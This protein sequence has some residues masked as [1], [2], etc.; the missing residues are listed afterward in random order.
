MGICVCVCVFFV[1]FD[2]LAQARNF[3]IEGGLPVSCLPLLTAGFEL[4]KSETPGMHRNVLIISDAVV[5][6]HILIKLICSINNCTFWCIYSH[7]EHKKKTI[8]V[9]FIIQCTG[10]I[11]CFQ[12]KFLICKSSPPLVYVSYIWQLTGIGCRVDSLYTCDVLE[13][14]TLTAFGIAKEVCVMGK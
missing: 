5:A 11:F 4:W 2:G 10:I 12:Y 1:N 3:R 6:D 14:A 7:S 9:K 8:K 13:T